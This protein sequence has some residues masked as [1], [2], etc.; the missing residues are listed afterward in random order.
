MQ[1]LDF[2]PIRNVTKFLKRK[3][4]PPLTPMPVAAGVEVLLLADGPAEAAGVPEDVP[5]LA[6]VLVDGPL[7]RPLH[8][9]RG[10]AVLAVALG[11]RG[12]QDVEGRALDVGHGCCR[13]SFEMKLAR[14]CVREGGCEVGFGGFGGGEGWKI[15]L[16]SSFAVLYVLGGLSDSKRG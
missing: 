10:H 1:Q 15:R 13:C 12:A 11:V 9:G 6:H 2:S 4:T 5:V 8:R 7:G 14:V 16:I 3:K